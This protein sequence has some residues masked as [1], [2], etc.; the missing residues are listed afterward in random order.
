VLWP[1]FHCRVD[2]AEYNDARKSGYYRVNR[3]FAQS[4][5]PLHREDDV[6]WVQDYHLIPL[7]KELRERGCRN[8]IGFFLHI[9]W[10]P[11]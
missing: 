7:G 2:L 10:P 11:A 8:R 4:L 1:V 3:L 5:M 9:P 6:I